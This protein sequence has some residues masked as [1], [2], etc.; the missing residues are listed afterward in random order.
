MALLKLKGFTLIEVLISICIVMIVFFTLGLTLTNLGKSQNYINKYKA[1]NYSKINI[2]HENN[3][4][5]NNT[6]NTSI[7]STTFTIKKEI[8]QWGKENKMTI[9]KTIVTNSENNKEVIHTIDYILIK[10]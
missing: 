3:K 7:I 2:V 10:K 6:S 8:E 4:S 5:E 9:I 1:Y